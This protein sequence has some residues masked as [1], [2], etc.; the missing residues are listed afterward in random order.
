MV[1]FKSVFFFV[2]CLSLFS[3]YCINAQKMVA[4]CYVT[5]NKDAVV[6]SML[7]FKGFKEETNT[8]REIQVHSGG[9]SQTIYPKDLYAYT[10]EGVFYKSTIF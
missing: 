7:K 1:Y 2:T 9:Q 8:Y 3:P 10:K 6:C 4:G 5:V